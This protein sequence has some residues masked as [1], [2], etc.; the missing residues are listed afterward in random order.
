MRRTFTLALLSALA[1]AAALLLVLAALSGPSGD[2]D[3]A[4]RELR[5]RISGFEADR[6]SLQRILRVQEES[7]AVLRRARLEADLLVAQLARENERTAADLARARQ[8]LLLDDRT[9]D[10]LLHDL[11]RLVGDLRARTDPALR[12]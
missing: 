10:S 9:P 8:T 3:A 5:E 4:Y 1:G 2:E 7:L 11:N 12:P 6:D